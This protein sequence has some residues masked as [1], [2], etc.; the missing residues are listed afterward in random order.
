M[1]ENYEEIGIC[2][3]CGGTYT[4]WGNNA[5]PINKGRCCDICNDTKVIPA[6][7]SKYIVGNPVKLYGKREEK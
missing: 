4:H 1:E 5:Y 7:M 3:I 6:R 2:S